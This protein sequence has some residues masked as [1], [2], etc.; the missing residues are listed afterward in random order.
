MFVFLSLSSVPDSQGSFPA[1]PAVQGHVATWSGAQDAQ[2][3]MVGS[4]S[5]VM[6]SSLSHDGHVTGVIPRVSAVSWYFLNVFGLRSIYGLI[7][8][9]DNGKSTRRETIYIIMHLQP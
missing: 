1:H 8:G 2:C 3:L 7:L 9:A 5:Q 4:L 6:M